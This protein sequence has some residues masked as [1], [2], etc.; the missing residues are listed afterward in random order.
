MEQD[1]QHF[2]VQ[3]AIHDV[4]GG[5]LIGKRQGHH[6]P[7]AEVGYQAQN[8][9]PAPQGGIE[10]L[11]ARKGDEFVDILRPQGLEVGNLQ[12]D[13]GEVLEVTPTDTPAMRFAELALES[14]FE[15]AQ[16]DP[17]MPGVHMVPDISQERGEPSIHV[18]WHPRG[19]IEQL[20]GRMHK[21]A[22]FHSEHPALPIASRTIS[23]EMASMHFHAPQCFLL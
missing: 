7:V 16:S 21:K 2:V 4:E 14:D 11:E 10:V 5:M 22:F 17:P 12:Q 23:T 13:M 19:Q 6:L 8:T 18:P 3:G 9:L 20:F 1:I 15:V